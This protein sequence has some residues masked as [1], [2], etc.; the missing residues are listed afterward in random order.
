MPTLVIG[1][2]PGGASSEPDRDERSGGGGSSG[3][4]A[5]EA[6]SKALD[7]RDYKG[8]NEAFKEMLQSADAELGGSDEP[9]P[10]SMPR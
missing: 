2:K 4:L 9:S 7:R 8:M 1:V 3:E 5:C 10:A 6:F